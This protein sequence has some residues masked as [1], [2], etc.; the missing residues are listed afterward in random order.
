MLDNVYITLTHVT[1][2]LLLHLPPHTPHTQMFDPSHV[3]TSPMEDGDAVDGEERE[4]ERDTK[5]AP[6]LLEG[7][8]INSE[9]LAHS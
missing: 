1:P 4:R 6:D 8:S 7:P 3:P 2:T 9:G 5:H